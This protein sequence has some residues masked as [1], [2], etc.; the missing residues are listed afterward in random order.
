MTMLP[1]EDDQVS[2][3]G[4]N[5]SDEPV[6]D[7]AGQTV[8]ADDDD[9][10]LSDAD[11]AHAKHAAAVV[12]GQA[13]VAPPPIETPAEPEKKKRRGGRRAKSGEPVSAEMLAAP[14]S[15]VQVSVTLN[16]ITGVGAAQINGI[17]VAHEPGIPCHDP[18]VVIPDATPSKRATLTEFLNDRKLGSND[19]APSLD[20]TKQAKTRLKVYA[21]FSTRAVAAAQLWPKDPT[22]Y[23]DAVSKIFVDLSLGESRIDALKYDKDAVVDLVLNLLPKATTEVILRSGITEL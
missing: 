15:D 6:T 10:P 14:P 20:F 19:L 8:T 4:E 22:R 9:A 11:L 21:K 7:A 23:F 1:F 5:T 12:T 2:L 17:A 16:P 3:D 13:S 18:P